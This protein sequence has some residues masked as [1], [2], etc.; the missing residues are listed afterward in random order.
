MLQ[1][2]YPIKIEMIG[3]LIVLIVSIV[4]IYADN[5]NFAWYFYLSYN[6]HSISPVL[7]AVGTTFSPK[8]WKG[9]IRKKK[10]V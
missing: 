10:I 7:S 4:V 3:I 8:F 6:I 9:G 1:N 2:N 5:K